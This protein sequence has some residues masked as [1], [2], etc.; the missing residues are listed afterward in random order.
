MA[1]RPRKGAWIEMR[2]YLGAQEDG[3]GRPRK[4]AWIEIMML[5]VGR[6]VPKS[7]PQGGVD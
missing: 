5:T 6:A 7:P 2:S 1:S 3:Q 4:G